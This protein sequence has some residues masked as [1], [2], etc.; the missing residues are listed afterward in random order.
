M[1][2][3]TIFRGD[4]YAIRRPLFTYALFDIDGDPFDLSGCV[5]RTTYKADLVAIEDDP[6]DDTAVDKH[7]IRISSLGAVT[8]QIGLYLA[9]TAI[10]GQL[11]ERFTSTETAAIPIETP[12]ISDVELVDVN[13]EKFTFPQSDFIVAINA[14][15][16]RS[17]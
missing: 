1:A 13:G 4:S 12:L 3:I 7:E 5:I 2:N 11:I 8:S 14:V 17:T 16:N 6:T 10:A 9:S 15:T